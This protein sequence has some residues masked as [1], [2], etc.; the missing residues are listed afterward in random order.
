[1]NTNQEVSTSGGNLGINEK[2]NEAEKRLSRTSRWMAM[3][4]E[5]GGDINKM[6]ED[7]INK[8]RNQLKIQREDSLNRLRE[9]IA[10]GT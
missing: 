5:R 6:A 9:M 10:R 4:E 8:F 3:D 2:K 1:M 7:F